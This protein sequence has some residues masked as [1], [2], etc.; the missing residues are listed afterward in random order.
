MVHELLDV[1]SGSA[2]K[3]YYYKLGWWA[4]RGSLTLV[5]KVPYQATIKYIS[6]TNK[7]VD[8]VKAL[9]TQKYNNK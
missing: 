2:V 3:F 1:A 7:Y 8:Y 5:I 6:V 4:A 9:M